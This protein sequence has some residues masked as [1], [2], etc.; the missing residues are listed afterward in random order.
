VV[1]FA[2]VIPTEGVVMVVNNQGVSEPLRR[3]RLLRIWAM[4]TI[5]PKASPSAELS[6]Y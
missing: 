4:M 6:Y 5:N 1:H 2:E 3:S